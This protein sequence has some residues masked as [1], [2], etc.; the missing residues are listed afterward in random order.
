MSEWFDH[1]QQHEFVDR[2]GLFVFVWSTSCKNIYQVSHENNFNCYTLRSAS[3]PASVVISAPPQMERCSDKPPCLRKA[4]LSRTKRSLWRRCACPP[5]LWPR[6]PL[7][8]R[9][10]NE[11]VSRRWAL[12]CLAACTAV[13]SAAATPEMCYLICKKKEKKEENIHLHQ[14]EQDKSRWRHANSFIPLR[15]SDTDVDSCRCRSDCYS[16]TNRK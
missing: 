8:H 7:R 13:F 9:G 4:S 6:L 14:V 15:C 12:P 16:I 5:D 3:S 11:A 10:R 1:M 2:W